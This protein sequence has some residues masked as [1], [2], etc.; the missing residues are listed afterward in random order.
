MVDKMNAE[1]RRNGQTLV[2]KEMTTGPL[3]PL[4]L[5]IVTGAIKVVLVADCRIHDNRTILF[6]AFVFGL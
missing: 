1:T 6:G 4:S 3:Y 2:L 5:E